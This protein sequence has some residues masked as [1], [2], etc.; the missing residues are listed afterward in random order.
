MD[1]D[2]TPP[3]TPTGVQFADLRP[4][5]I[6]DHELI[7]CIGGG[8][9]GEV[10]LARN[11]MGTY[12]AV[13]IVHRDRFRD[14]RPFER[15]YNGIQ[16]FEPVSRSHESQVDIL[17]VGRHNGCF[18]YVMELADDQERGQEIDPERY[19]PKNLETLL[20]RR[21][22]LTVDE[23]LEIALA[24][25]TGLAHLHNHELVH[26]DI[27]PSNIIFVH[28]MPKLADIGLVTGLDA[29]R[30][31]VGTEGYLPPEGP[32]TQRADIYSL[33]KVLYE[34]CTGRDRQEYPELPTLLEELPDRERLLE[35]NAII[36]RACRE[37][38]RQRYDSAE[39]MRQDLLLL[40]SGRS[41]RRMQR[42]ERHMAHVRQAGALTGILLLLAAGAYGYQ[43]RQTRLVE[44]LAA[45]NLH[46]ANES[47]ELLIRM[48]VAAGNRLV[49][50][51]D[52]A[53]ALLWFIEALQLMEDHPA[54]ET[55]HRVRIDSV[56]RHT[57]RVIQLFQHDSGVRWCEFSPDGTRIA[58]ASSDRTA[59]VWDVISGEPVTPPLE[60]RAGVLSAVFSPDGQWVLTASLDGT[61]RV[62]NATS[63]EPI[64]P[65]LEHPCSFAGPED[66]LT[67]SFSPDS[68]MVLTASTGGPAIL[69]DEV[70]G[71]R[72]GPE[73]NSVTGPGG[74]VSA[75]FSPEGRRIV[76][77]NT[78]RTVTIW[79]IDTAQPMFPSIEVGDVVNFASFSPDGERILVGTG[80]RQYPSPIRGTARIWNAMSGDPI[81]AP[82]PHQTGVRMGGFS[83]DGT[84]V[85][86]A[87]EQVGET[88]IARIWDATTGEQIG[89]D[90]E[91]HSRIWTAVFSPDGNRVAT[92]SEHRTARV[93][94]AK[95]GRALT[96]PLKHADWVGHASFSP[97]GNSLATA[98]QDG[99]VRVWDLVTDADGIAVG[100]HL[101][102]VPHASD[103]QFSGDGG[104]LLIKSKAT[105][106]LFD[107]E[108]L[109][110][111]D[112][113]PLVLPTGPRS[114]ASMAAFNH[115]AS[116]I[117]IAPFWWATGSR[118]TNA[119][120][121]SAT[122]G[123]LQFTV[124]H[125]KAL[126]H[127]IF[128]FDGRQLLTTSDDHTAR[129][130]DAETGEPRSP[131]L[132]HNDVVRHGSFSPDGT[133]IVTASGTAVVWDWAVG[134]PA[135]PPLE[136]NHVV[137]YACYSPDGLRIATASADQTAR[138]WDAQTGRPITAPLHQSGT[139][140]GVA[141]S[142][143]SRA[144]VSWG[145]APF[146]NVW[147][148]ETGQRL[149]P[150]LNHQAGLIWVEFS[151]DGRYIVT[152]SMDNSA[153]VWDAR[154]GEAVSIPLQTGEPVFRAKFHPDGRRVVTASGVGGA[155]HW[156]LRQME[157]PMEDV[158]RLAAVLTGHQIDHTLSRSRLRSDQ[159]M[160]AFRTLQVRHPDQFVVRRGQ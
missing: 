60:H 136:H 36:A 122:T 137:L 121:W 126:N 51:G 57:P 46:L 105:A 155:R 8:S 43:A 152:A 97:D 138:I 112:W 3:P 62:W 145:L 143:D 133:R 101:E 111:S 106:I 26:R 82:M 67:A 123:E 24:L 40:Q 23:T 63:G 58:S 117:L 33:G 98:S 2:D 119:Q 92:C 22:R 124:A 83:P 142:P 27:K 15:E 41:V 88:G 77:A 6:P 107:L 44:E 146:A 54:R 89:A 153:R 59:R 66:V 129:V 49:D 30:S 154:T 85:V 69:W 90:L 56:L 151:P 128:S 31:F 81:T 108:G 72:L 125:E 160:P 35:L 7:R 55:V 110:T 131:P 100:S 156:T 48:Q 14:Q 159:I 1:H 70:T 116:K 94:D 71:E 16:R 127:A 20:K 91:Q 39:A 38:A 102:A 135:L 28:G 53:E 113:R 65:P 158:N 96:P 74:V 86:T 157:W 75:S 78:D 148:T 120:V 130:W 99:L 93:W 76:T 9:Y 150:P 42:L 21:E 10:W 17:H 19:A 114:G 109:D 73:L 95:N 47:R 45:H 140:M 29:T 104:K 80:V 25:T 11:V 52:Y 84:R 12:R 141:F 79:D 118:D 34:M 37:E 32:G 134:R 144:L 5:P 139:V 4:P 132:R 115:H 149:L 50:E 147:D 61:A 18:Y 64:S 68:T 103:A 13:K 87:E